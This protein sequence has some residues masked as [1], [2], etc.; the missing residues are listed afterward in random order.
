[1]NLTTQKLILDVV[2]TGNSGYIDTSKF[3]N[4]NLLVVSVGDAVDSRA[5]TTFYG[6]PDGVNNYKLGITPVLS[7]TLD[8]DG[9]IV[10][11]ETALQSNLYQVSGVHNYIYIDEVATVATIGIKVYLI[12]QEL[13]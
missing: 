12:S 7:G 11:D 9:V 1:M 10:Y 5:T 13:I 4:I 2:T 8:G 6:S 3:V